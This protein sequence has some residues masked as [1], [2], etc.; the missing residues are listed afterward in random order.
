MQVYSQL[1]RK[2]KQKNLLV[3]VMKV[4]GGQ[5]NGVAYEGATVLDPIS[6]FYE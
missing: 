2:A 4:Q 3:P 1:L 6:G 5:D